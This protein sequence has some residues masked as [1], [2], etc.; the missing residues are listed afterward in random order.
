MKITT[1]KKRNNLLVGVI[2]VEDHPATCVHF[3]YNKMIENHF[4][5][6]SFDDVLFNTVLR[7]K[8]VYVHL[9]E[10]QSCNLES[11]LI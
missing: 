6:S 10:S 3:L 9:K 4:L 5:F 11:L 2:F 8:T 1:T 7:Y